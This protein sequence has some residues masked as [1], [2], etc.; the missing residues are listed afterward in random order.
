[1]A[2]SKPE[3]NAPMVSPPKGTPIPRKRL[4][5]RLVGVLAGVIVVVASIMAWLLIAPTPTPTPTTEPAKVIKPRKVPK[6]APKAKPG[7]K[8]MPKKPQEVMQPVVAP[9]N[10][11]LSRHE[12]SLTNAYR[13]AAEG[14]IRF[15]PN[16][17]RETRI[18]TET[19]DLQIERLLSI[20]PGQ[21]VLVTL[22]YDRFEENFRKSLKT[23]IVVKPTDS[24]EV[25]A[26]KEAVQEVRDDFE[27]RMNAGEDIAAIMRETDKELRRLSQY[28]FNLETEIRKARSNPDLTE[29]NMRDYVEA[30]NKM[31]SDNGLP[32][33]KYPEMWFRNR[34]LHQ[35][36]E[37]A[38]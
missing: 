37:N 19:S 31:L 2:W 38:Q 11:P 6:P 17:R 3:W 34:R 15:I 16:R 23:P 21:L 36:K 12:Q 14:K 10:P 24:E 9:A 8:Q 26:M 35:Q 25:K 7:V 1:M 20:Q 33:L 29:E 5:F 30:A 18:F 28:R 13:L 4:N 32:E 27:R 22:N